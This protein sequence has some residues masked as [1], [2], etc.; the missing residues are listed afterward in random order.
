MWP[1][2]RSD[3]WVAIWHFV[4]GFAP[5]HRFLPESN[6]V[7]TLQKFF[8]WDCIPRPLVSCS[9]CHS[10]LDYG[11]THNRS[12]KER[13]SLPPKKQQKP[14]TQKQTTTRTTQQQQQTN[15]KWL[16][17]YN[18]NKQQKQNNTKTTNQTK[19]QQK[20][21]TAKPCMKLSK[22]CPS[23]NWKCWNWM[24]NVIFI[25]II[26][27]KIIK[28]WMLSFLECQGTSCTSCYF[29]T[30]KRAVYTGLQ[31]NFGKTDL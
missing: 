3:G 11:N 26:I 16:N 10:S 13:R 4:L 12:T 1:V 27:K 24:L 28:I 14:H 15:K 22:K 31:E 5:A 20:T 25:I 2:T 21:T 7:P 29:D 8:G 9:P 19:Q 18:T 6:S 30:F 23:W 17:N